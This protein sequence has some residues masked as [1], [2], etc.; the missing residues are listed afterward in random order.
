M[1]IDSIL[2][3]LND[4]VVFSLIYAGILMIGIHFYSNKAINSTLAAQ[5]ERRLKKR[6]MQPTQ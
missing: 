3:V 1:T 2:K 6:K 5:K 4:P